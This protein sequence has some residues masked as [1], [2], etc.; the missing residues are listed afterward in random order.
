MALIRAKEAT[1][2]IGSALASVGTSTTLETQITGTVD[3]S[4]KVRDIKI[5]GGESS[6]EL[7]P[8]FG[9][10]TNG[11]QNMDSY[12]KP[13]TLREFSGTLILN[14]NTISALNAGSTTTIGA[15]GYTRLQGDG[16]LLKRALY[17]KLVDASGA[18]L[19]C[20]LN[21][22]TSVKL[23]DIKLDSEGFAEQEITFKCL[24]RDYFE[25]Y[26]A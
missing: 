2:K 21:N 18:I 24:A 8:L 6:T 15:T 10:D 1:I 20:V 7:V 26:H 14:D 9:T 12:N 23:G 17:C 16:A 3:Y 5:S 25:E 13:A 22:S 11:R 4:G 19:N